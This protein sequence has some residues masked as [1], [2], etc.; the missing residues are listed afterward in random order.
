MRTKHWLSA[1]A[2]LL[3]FG[4]LYVHLHAAPVP[5]PVARS[6]PGRYTVTRVTLVRTDQKGRQ[7]QREQ[8]VLLDTA[9]GKA[10]V[11]EEQGQG[12]EPRYKWVLAAEAPK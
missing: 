8:Q 7:L 1:A 6:Q 5:E 11:L 10:W 3:A 12:K 4:L 9:T 2:A